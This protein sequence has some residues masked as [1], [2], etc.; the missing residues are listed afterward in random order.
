M[1]L[2]DQK[3]IAWFQYLHWAD[4][5]FDRYICYDESPATEI[6]I[7]FQWFASEYV[8]I[9]GWREVDFHDIDIDELLSKNQNS[10]DLLRRAR[11]AVFHYQQSPFDKRLEEFAKEFHESGWLVDLH[12]LFL[13]FMLCYPE[14]IY[15][16]GERRE[17]FANSF[18]EIVGWKP[19]LLQAT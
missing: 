3:V 1:A 16:Y 10:I 14:S 4:I 5:N 13:K 6:A 17:E 11:N 12:Q 18:Y 9:E 2:I 7:A 15:P 8:V 19:C